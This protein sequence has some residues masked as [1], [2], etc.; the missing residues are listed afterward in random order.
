[1]NQIIL[2]DIGNVLLKPIHG[3]IL[4]ELFINKN[5]EI[6]EEQFKEKASEVLN[7]SFFG[8]ITLD[9]TWS[10]L[11]EIVNITDKAIMAE[12]KDV[13]VIR[14]EELLEYIKKNL[15]KKY[16][17]GLISDLSQ[18][19]LS[20]FKKYYEDLYNICDKNLIYISIYKNKTKKANSERYFQEIFDEIGTKNILFI[21]DEIDNIKS[22]EIVGFKTIQFDGGF[23][24]WKTSNK[25]II[26]FFEERRF[27]E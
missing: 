14:N 4:N 5:N 10:K 17:I 23:N 24:S 18:I 22:A 19:G 12:I 15:S 26:D 6:T 7:K 25:K 9:E 8:N 11:F 27:E 21:D 20:V 3:K 13:E 2:L 16:R 1:M